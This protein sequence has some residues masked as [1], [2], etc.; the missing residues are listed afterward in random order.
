MGGE[1]YEGGSADWQRCV[2]QCGSFGLAASRAGRKLN[3]FPCHDVDIDEGAT[4]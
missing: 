3:A 1:G 4:G 2:P